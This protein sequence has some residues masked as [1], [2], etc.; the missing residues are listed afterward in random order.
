MGSPAGLR[1]GDGLLR[2]RCSPFRSSTRH[3]LRPASGGA[4]AVL[5]GSGRGAAGR[6]RAAARRTIDVFRAAD[7][8]CRRPDSRLLDRLHGRRSRPQKVFRLPEPLRRG[9]AA[10]RAGRQLPRP[11]RRLGRRGP[12]VLSADRLL[13]VPPQRRRGGQEGVHR[14]PSRRH[15]PGHRTHGALRHRRIGGL[16][17]GVRRCTTD[18]RRHPQR[19]RPAAAARRLRQE[20]A[21]APAVVARRRHGGPHPGVGAHPRR[22]HGDRRGRSS[23]SRRAPRPRSSSSAR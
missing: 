9:H 16:P 21:G 10:A 4:H 3:A 19:R 17:H 14:Q 7:H 1:R 23:T 15:R 5:L 11:L 6:L 18:E 20:R 13:V 22:H 12:G 2:L 8:R